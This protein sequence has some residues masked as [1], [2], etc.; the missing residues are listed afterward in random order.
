MGYLTE[1]VDALMARNDTIFLRGSQIL[2]WFLAEAG[3]A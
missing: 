1:V 3:R 2:D